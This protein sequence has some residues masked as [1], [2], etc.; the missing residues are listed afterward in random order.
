MLSHGNPQ[1]QMCA[2]PV[3]FIFCYL[4]NYL[5]LILKLLI[6]SAAQNLSGPYWSVRW[7]PQHVPAGSTA[8]WQHT[9]KVRGFFYLFFYLWSPFS[10]F[11][12]CFVFLVC[13]KNFFVCIG[14]YVDIWAC[15]WSRNCWMEIVLTGLQKKR[16]R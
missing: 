13:S 10:H 6:L 9:W 7:P 1:A 4:V 11:L 12:Y 15:P 16:F 5:L 14:N 8:A 2:N 3:H